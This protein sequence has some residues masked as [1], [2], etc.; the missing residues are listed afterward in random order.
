MG[1]YADQARFTFQSTQDVKQSF[2]CDVVVEPCVEI[3]VIH[4]GPSTAMRLSN[5]ARLLDFGADL[6]LGPMEVCRREPLQA[7]GGV[8]MRMPDVRSRS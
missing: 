6:L 4:P 3:L 1:A 7:R 8:V 2:P 5:R